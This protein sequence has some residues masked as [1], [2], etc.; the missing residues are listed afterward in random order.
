MYKIPLYWAQYIEWHVCGL[1]ETDG[2]NINLRGGKVSHIFMLPT[3]GRETV[4]ELVRVHQWLPRRNRRCIVVGIST[5]TFIIVA[6]A[7]AY[8]KLLQ[9][10]TSWRTELWMR[11]SVNQRIW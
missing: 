4:T 8:A 10:C 6:Y 1:S 11:E 2:N 7:S 3:E 9:D 5:N